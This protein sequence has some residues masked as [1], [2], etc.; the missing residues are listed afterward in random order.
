VQHSPRP[1][2]CNVSMGSG[3]LR[4]GGGWH[5]GFLVGSNAL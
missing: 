5:F 2:C 4:H 1:K 3:N